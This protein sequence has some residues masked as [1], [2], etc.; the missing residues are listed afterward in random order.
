MKKNSGQGGMSLLELMVALTIFALV[1]VGVV[2]V[3]V[4]AI[5]YN[6]EARRSIEARN[7]LSSHSEYLKTLPM[8]DASRLDDGDP[9]DLPDNINPDHTFTDTVRQFVVNWN[10][11][12]VNTFQQDVRIFVNWQDRR[13]MRRAMSTDINLIGD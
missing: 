3:M 10:I 9:N 7:V 13:G 1:L 8:S 5:G 2:P 12:T 4:L 11:R 6:R